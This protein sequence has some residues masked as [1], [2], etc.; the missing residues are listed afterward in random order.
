M[1][2]RHGVRPEPRMGE[3]AEPVCATDQAL[4]VSVVYDADQTVA[5][6]Q[7]KGVI[8]DVDGV[9]RATIPR[10]LKVAQAFAFAVMA[11]R[12]GRGS[13]GRFDMVRG[14]EGGAA[15]PTVYK[16]RLDRLP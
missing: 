5:P 9:R 1:L 12:V 4:R 15:Q 10:L 7:E 8:D 14:E 6:A 2:E 3:Q 11:A 13:K 16:G